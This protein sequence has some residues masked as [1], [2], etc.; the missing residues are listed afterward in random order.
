MICCAIRARAWVAF[1]LL[2]G[3]GSPWGSPGVVAQASPEIGDD[4]TALIAAIEAPQ[5]EE[6]SSG[7]SPFR[8]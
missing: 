5:P 8:R 2:L 7:P 1:L 4:P 3:S 6:K